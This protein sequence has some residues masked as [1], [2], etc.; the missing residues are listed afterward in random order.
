MLGDIANSRAVRELR[1][2][3][4]KMLEHFSP[5]VLAKCNEC[6]EQLSEWYSDYNV[7]KGCTQM[8]CRCGK[9]SNW[10]SHEEYRQS[11]KGGG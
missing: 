4:Y 2:S 1:R 7:F 10:H 3:Y 11:L 8:S 6:G 5:V 9:M